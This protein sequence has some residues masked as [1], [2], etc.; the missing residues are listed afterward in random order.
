MTSRVPEL[1]RRAFAVATSGRPGPVLLDVPEDVCHGEHDFA[2]EDFAIDPTTLQR[3]GAAHPARSRRHLPR[4]CPDRARQA[5]AHPGRRRHPSL[6]GVRGAAGV[7]RGAVDPGRAYDER[8]GRHRLH[9]PALGRAVRPLFADRQRADRGV[10]LS[11]RRRLQARRDRHQTVC[12]AVALDP[13]DPSRHRRR[14]DRPLPAGRG[15]AVGR[16]AGRARG[17]RRSAR[18]GRSGRPA[19]RAPT[20]SPRSRTAWRH[21]GTRPPRGSIP[22]SGR[23][24]W[25]GS[26]ASSTRPCRPTAS[27]SPMAGLPGIGP[28]SSTIRKPPGRHFIP[29]RGSGLDR[30]WAARRD[31]GGARR[32]RH[33][34]RRDHRRRRLQ[35]DAGRA[36]NR[37][38]RRR[39]G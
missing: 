34:G 12:A 39:S 21:G 24:T 38:P 33:A 11:R 18:R 4:R 36:R 3:A 37:A 1:L 17:S 30:L 22:A 8:Q 10:G 14:G 20:T 5:A 25:P 31:R 27:S 29:D 15:G 35:H 23:S 26:A 28:G 2:P 13:A 6:G 9:A 16:R 19:P 32:A 7:C